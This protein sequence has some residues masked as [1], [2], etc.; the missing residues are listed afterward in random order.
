MRGLAGHTPRRP[1][2]DAA[3]QIA[4]RLG[5]IRDRIDAAAS[6]A[7]RDAAEVTLVAV[8]KTHPLSTVRAAVEAGLSDLGENRVQD[9][10]EKSDALPG[11][12]LGGDVRWHAIGSLQRN[13]A[14]EVAAR[15]DLFH[16]L[17]SPRL[18]RALDAKAAEAGRVLDVLVQ[19]NI[20]GEASKSGAPPDTAHDLAAVAHAYGHLRVV[21][22]MGMAAPADSAAEAERVVRPA[23]VRLRTLRDTAPFDAPALSMGM[24]GDFEIAVEEGATLVRLGSALFG[25]RG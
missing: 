19:V 21:G 16:A 24:S 10:V 23:F 18:A 14:R 11:E 2:T 3:A 9:L 6:R 25:A 13:K 22:W 4:D 8:T 20:S 1:V 5:R 7:G 15:A 17:D 12:A